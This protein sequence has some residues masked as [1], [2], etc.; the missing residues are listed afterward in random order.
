MCVPDCLL[1][2][3]RA[4]LTLSAVKSFLSYDDALAF[5]SGRNPTSATDGSKPPRFYGVA[6]GRKPGVYMDWSQAQ[7]AI[8]GWKGPK[9]KKFDTR[10]EAEAFV[11]SYGALS[12]GTNSTVPEAGSEDQAGAAEKRP[13]KKAKTTPKVPTARNGVVVVYT[14]GSSLGNGRNGATAGVGVY[15]G[16]S[17]PRFGPRCPFVGNHRERILTTSQQEHLGALAGRAPNESA[18][19]ADSHPPRPRNG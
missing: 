3:V 14:D 1:R 5:A 16:E 4:P 9:F 12:K 17:D 7:E 6:V 15:F 18:C 2:L 19:R 10:A 13:A 8:V 11:R